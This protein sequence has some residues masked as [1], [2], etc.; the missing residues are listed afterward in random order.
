[1][2]SESADRH[3]HEN[4][5]ESPGREI[6]QHGQPIQGRKAIRDEHPGDRHSRQCRADNQT[7]PEC[8]SGRS[9]DVRNLL[10][11]R[12]HGVLAL[13]RLWPRNLGLYCRTES[14]FVARLIERSHSIEITLPR[15]DGH[16]TE[17][18]SKQ[19]F[20]IQLLP[21]PLGQ[22]TSIDVIP[23]PIRFAID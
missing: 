1:M 21:W 4:E 3:K 11:P 6:P 14:A 13:N 18:R 19:E 2:T 15:Y 22:F 10:R 9:I 7:K 23:R 8:R 20:T 16:I 12:G 5:D 17:R